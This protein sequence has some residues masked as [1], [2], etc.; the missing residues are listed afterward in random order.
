MPDSTQWV[1]KMRHMEMF[2][3]V[4][5][6]GSVSAAA[7]M[8]YVTQPAVSKLIQY[9]E[10]RLGYRLFERINNRL[11]P[12]AEAQTLYREVERV[13]LAAQAVNECAIAL[14]V[15]P[16]RQLRIC[17]STTLATVLIPYALATIKRAVPGLE[18]QW[19]SALISDM[20]AQLLGKKVDLAISA[21]PV[22]HEHLHSLAFM[23]GSMVCAVPTDHEWAGRE[24]VSLE[25]LAGQDLVLF[26]RDIPFGRIL[27][28]EFEE[29][30]L[31][32]ASILNF[33]TAV[34][35]VALVRQ[36]L[37]IAVIDE[38]VAQDC[39]LAVVRLAQPIEFEISFVYSRFEPLS[40]ASLHLMKILLERA[41]SLN[42]LIKGCKL[43][44][45]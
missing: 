15:Q 39:G 7:R 12:T 18:I 24:E 9:V 31:K 38:F 45:V 36:G 2:R 37:G 8:M 6:T 26:R 33:T 16:A 41:A 19:Q 3:A 34:E 23:R 29:R 22:T 27:A 44:K 40:E 21:L 25:E 42:R 28:G 4:M 43:P 32:Y 20:P 30:D 1:F 17:C 14:S 11:V 10:S 13:Y 35:G 5:L